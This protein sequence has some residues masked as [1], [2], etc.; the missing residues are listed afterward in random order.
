MKCMAIHNHT[1]RYVVF[2]DGTIK[3]LINN[4]ILKPRKNPNGYLVVTLEGEQLSVHR[5]VATHFIANPYGF[6][7]VNHKDG[8]KENNCVSNLEWCTAEM[9]AQHALKT[10]LRKGFVPYNVKL[11][12]LNRV[13]KGELISEVQLDLP[14]THPNT[15]SRMLRETAKKEGLESE[16]KQAM[17]IRRKNVAIRNLSKINSGYSK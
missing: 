16:W 17:Q 11:T 2:E 13:L 3:S 7:Q 5:I 9:N 14:N 10:G 15:L 6:T 4:N 8:D 12:L 1:Q